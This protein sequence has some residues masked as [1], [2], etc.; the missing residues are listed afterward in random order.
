M[1]LGVEKDYEKARYWFEKSALKGYFFAETALALLY[2]DIEF[3]RKNTFFHPRGGVFFHGNR[4]VNTKLGKGADK[5][6]AQYWLSKS[7]YRNDPYSRGI[8]SAL[9]IRLLEGR[10]LKKRAQDY[11]LETVQ[12]YQLEAMIDAPKISC[13]YNRN[14]TM[15]EK[16]FIK[17]KN[18]VELHYL[19]KPQYIK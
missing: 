17:P 5:G 1:G 10:M 13:F 14:D 6:M 19:E 8:A 3:N 2:L 15:P 4:L 9:G 18:M 11:Q 16:I 12:D 7:A